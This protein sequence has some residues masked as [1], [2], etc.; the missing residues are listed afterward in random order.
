MKGG[1]ACQRE[2][3]G[4]DG[5]KNARRRERGGT[6]GPEQ[7]GKLSRKGSISDKARRAFSR[8]NLL[9]VLGWSVMGALAWYA[10]SAATDLQTF[11]PFEILGV[12]MWADDREIKKA[13]R[14]LSLK[15]HPDKNPDPSSADY[16][17]TKISKAYEAL[18]DPVARENYEKYGHPDGPAAR[19]FGVALP[20]FLFTKEG[21]MS[22]LVVGG[23][24]AFGVMVPLLAAVAYLVKSRKFNSSGILQETLFNYF[25]SQYRVKES[26][27]LARIPETVVVAAEIIE[28]PVRAKDKKGLEEL[29][30]LTRLVIKEKDAQAK[31]F[32]RKLPLV[33]AHMLLLAHLERY[34]IDAGM[35]DQYVQIFALLPK[36]LD[37]MMNVALHARPGSLG[38]LQASL[39]ILHFSQ[40]VTQ[41]IPLQQFQPVNSKGD[42]VG[43][44]RQLPH[45]TVDIAKKLQ[46]KRVK[47]IDDLLVLPRDA[48]LDLYK[49]VGLDAEAIE[50]VE[51]MVGIMPT[52]FVDS[53]VGVEGEEGPVTEGD[54]VTLKLSI[55][56]IRG[57]IDGTKASTL[58]KG[59]Q[60]FAPRCPCSRVE[61]WWFLYGDA[62]SN[63]VIASSKAKLIKAEIE[64]EE[65]RDELRKE[66]NWESVFTAHRSPSSNEI[67]AIVEDKLDHGDARVSF[68]FPAPKPGKHELQVYILSEVYVG[69]DLIVPVTLNVTKKSQ[70]TV[71]EEAQPVEEEEEDAT[72]Y[73]TEDYG[74]EVSDSEDEKENKDG[75]KA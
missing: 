69:R 23:L 57:A 46:K 75:N 19:S 62:K 32:K 13:Y 72:D 61:R 33:K 7:G 35:Q 65:W 73:D 71:V 54:V 17:A 4:A 25:S 42:A 45:V 50:D 31:F 5:R 68:T 74:T 6:D 63:A 34:D 47:T 2:R 38:W 37:E 59:V 28:M 27:A 9:L 1:I 22:A 21:N 16:F 30:K 41:A 58:G 56:L 26:H 40:C 15:Y 67:E 18:T 51:E 11:D 39:S 60:A 12:P 14:K 66:G 70:A 29:E 10:G 48:R 24:V 64:G 55:K 3:E 36:L 8:K 44:L 49:E 20:K 53:K 52:I 43:A